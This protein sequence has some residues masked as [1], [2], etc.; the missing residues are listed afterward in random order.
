MQCAIDN[1]KRRF[2]VDI[3]REIKRIKK[4]LAVSKFKYPKFWSVIK[5]QFNKNNINQ[6]LICPMNTLCELKIDNAK[7]KKNTLP[8][9]YFVVKVEPIEN[10][11]KCKKVEEIIQKY[12]LDLYK[13]LGDDSAMDYCFNTFDDLLEDIKKIYISN[14]YLDLMSFLIDR[15]FN[16]T[17][18]FKMEQKCN[19]PLLLNILYEIN[20]KAVLKLFSKNIQK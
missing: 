16:I 1:S 13:S 18:D 19:R 15:F 8:L 2:D 6:D 7:F 12:S 11:R 9:S 3:S 14:N 5:P 20:P 17:Q 10:K 4:D